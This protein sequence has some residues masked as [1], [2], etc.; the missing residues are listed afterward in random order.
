MA[1]I[2]V[3]EVAARAGVSIS[4]VSRVLNSPDKVSEPTRSRVMSAVDD[5]GFVPKAEA[6]ARA[7]KIQG[8]IGVLAPFFTYP[9]FVQRLRGV[10]AAL[11]DSSYEL[12]IYVV[13]SAVQRDA[14]LSTLSVTRRVDALIVMALPFGDAIAE[15][16]LAHDLATVLVEFARPGFS[17]IEIDNRAGGRMAAEYLLGQGY[18]RLAFVGD[19]DLPEYA[20]HT[21]DA[22]LDGYR[23]ALAAAGVPLPD[24]YVAL[25]PHGQEPAR[26]ATRALLSL[27]TPP[28]AVFAASD[29]QAMGVLKAARECGVSVPRDLAVLG[30]DD[31]EAADYIGL[32]TVRQPLDESGRIAADLVLR[33]LASGVSSPQRIRLSLTLAPRE[34]T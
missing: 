1:R 22:R 14:Y 4:T 34:T 20:I 26:R 17:S 6:A 24:D 18:E 21:S 8:R 3:Y 32:S 7:R 27:P 13:D 2:T 33:L 11:A 15:R 30:F 28:N 12:V 10:A 29:T 19:T 9:S 16:L 25:A 31:L 5:L 23:A